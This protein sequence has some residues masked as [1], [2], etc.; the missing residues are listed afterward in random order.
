[1]DLVPI[2]RDLL[3]RGEGV[4]LPG[5]GTLRVVYHPAEI[6]HGP[7]YLIPPSGEMVYDF[8]RSQNDG[9]M[10]SHL[11]RISGCS[12]GEAKIHVE[13]FTEPIWIRLR[14]GKPAV[15]AGLGTFT[16]GQSERVTFEPDPNL[17]LC[18]DAYGL[19]PFR[20]SPISNERKG[21]RKNR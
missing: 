18:P 5:L 7:D 19:T 8:S 20:M 2:I 1:V 3:F 17:I 12:S 6:K 9:V 13:A 10:E 14:Q 11:M 21:K 4:T 16:P 15:I